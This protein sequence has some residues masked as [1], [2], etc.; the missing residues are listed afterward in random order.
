MKSDRFSL[1]A[2]A[3]W[4]PQ[5]SAGSLGPFR[6]GLCVLELFSSTDPA[7]LVLDG[8]FLNQ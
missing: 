4:K 5:L 7:F 1:S 8:C 2:A 6:K 3:L